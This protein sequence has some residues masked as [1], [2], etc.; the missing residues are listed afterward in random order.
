[1]SYVRALSCLAFI[2]AG[3]MSG[4][5]SGTAPVA[6]TG[7][8]GSAGSGESAMIAGS[9]NASSSMGSAGQ[10]STGATGVPSGGNSGGGETS[11]AAGSAGASEGMEASVDSG[12]SANAADEGGASCPGAFCEDF[13]DGG[14]IDMSKWEVQTMGGAT[15]EVQSQNVAHGKYA[16]HFHGLGT[17]TGSSQAYAYLITKSAP[18]SLQVHNFGRAYF[19]IAPKPTSVDTG[20]IFGGTAGFPKPTYLSIAEHSGGWQLGFIKLQGSP[21]GESQAYPTGQ[22]PVMTW[23]CLEWEFNDQPDTINI[24][25]DNGNGNSMGSLNSM[26]VAYP[27]N[28]PPGTIFN[29]MTSGLVGGFVDFGFGFYDWHPSGVPFDVYYDDI[30][31]DSKAVNCL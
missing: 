30:V 26:D 24:V 15:V 5:N 23:F 25:W 4:C 27:A 14:Q 13:E 19:Y 9:G 28:N 1:M 11:G 16:A 7:T 3:W 8:S 29:S 2:G 10:P 21:G 31:L 12:P 18:S 20:L 17:P 22:M 6:G